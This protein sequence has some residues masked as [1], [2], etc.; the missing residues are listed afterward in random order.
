MSHPGLNTVHIVVQ[1]IT[2][3]QV[4]ALQTTESI[5][6]TSYVYSRLLLALVQAGMWQAV[7]SDACTWG[8]RRQE[9]CAEMEEPLFPFL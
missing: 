5:I 7:S 1:Y 2:Y 6:Q 8:G 9:G 4:K 3:S